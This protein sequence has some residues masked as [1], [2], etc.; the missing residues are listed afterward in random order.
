MTLHEHCCTVW[1]T[2][3]CYLKELKAKCN[4]EEITQFEKDIKEDSK[5]AS[6]IYS[7]TVD[8]KLIKSISAGDCKKQ[9]YGYHESGCQ[10]MF[11]N[12]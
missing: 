2:I 11:V 1:D 9:K 6:I 10:H 5:D 12:E 4:A 8:G 7:H 3:D